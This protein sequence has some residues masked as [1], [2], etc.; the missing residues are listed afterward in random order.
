ME[1]EKN[2]NKKKI[3]PQKLSQIVRGALTTVLVVVV[4]GFIKKR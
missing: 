4:V 1:N 3:T 2:K